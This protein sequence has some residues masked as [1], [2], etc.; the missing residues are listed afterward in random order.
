MV[1]TPK[2]VRWLAIIYFTL[3]FAAPGHAQQRT[4]GFLGFGPTNCVLYYVSEPTRIQRFDICTQQALPDFN[5]TQLPDP[6]GVQ[7][8]QSLADGGRPDRR[9]QHHAS[10]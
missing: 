9:R 8:I 6:R 5:T 10:K 4:G 7:Q 2:T 1:A 3:L